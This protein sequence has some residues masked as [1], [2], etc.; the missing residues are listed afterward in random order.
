[1]PENFTVSDQLVAPGRNLPI[2][3]SSP[4]GERQL[5]E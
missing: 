3:T 4:A 1:M 5:N 2:R